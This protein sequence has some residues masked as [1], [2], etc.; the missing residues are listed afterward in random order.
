MLGYLYWGVA[1]VVGGVFVASRY[2][3]E[4]QC[5]AKLKT[6]N[7]LYDRYLDYKYSNYHHV[8]MENHTILI[9]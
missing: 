7:R 9:E 4:N 2:R 3:Q 1:M 6:V 8:I 5:W